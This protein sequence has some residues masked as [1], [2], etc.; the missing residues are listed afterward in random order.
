LDYKYDEELRD[1]PEEFQRIYAELKIEAALITI[2]SVNEI[3]MTQ[4][5]PKRDSDRT[6]LTPRSVLLSTTMTIQRYLP[7]HSVPGSSVPFLL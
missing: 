3:L 6:P 7:A 4:P 5:E 2:V 1:D